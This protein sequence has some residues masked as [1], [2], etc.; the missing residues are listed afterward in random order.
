M[1]IESKVTLLTLLQFVGNIFLIALAGGPFSSECGASRQH[2]RTDQVAYYFG[3]EKGQRGSFRALRMTCKHCLPSI[4]TGTTLMGVVSDSTH[5]VCASKLKSQ[6]QLIRG[7]LSTLEVTPGKSALRLGRHTDAATDT[8]PCMM[9][10]LKVIGSIVRRLLV[11]I[12]DRADCQIGPIV[13]LVDRLVQVF[14][15]CEPAAVL[16]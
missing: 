16:M 12:V 9:V 13:R 2:R 10:V 7:I 4:A 3:A 15:K 8:G 14:N 11:E 6:V 5:P 1:L